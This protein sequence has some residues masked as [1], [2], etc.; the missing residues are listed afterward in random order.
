MN[1][2]TQEKQLKEYATTAYQCKINKLSDKLYHIVGLGHS[3]VTI[4]IG[5]TSVLLVDAL[6][7]DAR[8]LR[9][10]QLIKQWTDKPV[11]T[12]I[13]T[14]SHPDHRG[15]SFAFKDT[16]ET[17]IQSNPRKQTLAYMDKIS[18]HLEK[19]TNYQFG[20]LL[21]GD[22][23]ITEGLG[24]REGN[25]SNDG[26]TNVLKPNLMFS[27]ETSDMCIDGINITLISAPGETND[28][29]NVYFKD[30]KAMCCGDNL[31][32][33][34][35]NLYAIRGTQYRDLSTWIDSLRKLNNYDINFLCRGHSFLLDDKNQ[36]KQN[37]NVLADVLESI[38]F[39]TLDCINEGYSEIET[40]KIVKIPEEYSNLNQLKEFYGLLKWGVRS[41]Y[42]GYIGWFNANPTNLDPLS[43]KEWADTL[44]NLI[45]KEKLIEA[46]KQSF[47]NKEF[48]KVLQLCDLYNESEFNEDLNYYRKHSLIN[49]GKNTISSNARNYYL[50]AA[51]EIR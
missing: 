24:I 39:Q 49:L 42:T 29:L 12:I 48:Q 21:S 41:I 44:V 34:F 17:I 25:F 1:Q 45:S 30:E 27:E 36:I 6:D 32:E 20:H 15:G 38:L 3:N 47:E 19:R 11:K 9:L 43:E 18:K 10:K 33:C 4:A 50:S 5:D 40:S 2:T 26:K 7:S 31:Y 22:D 14:H 13:Y 28:T 16:V 46:I 51:K 23:F 35:P 8:G 37:I